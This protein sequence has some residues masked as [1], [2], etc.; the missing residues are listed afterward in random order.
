MNVD[1]ASIDLAGKPKCTLLQPASATVISS[2][3][4]LCVEDG[5]VSQ[6]PDEESS[7]ILP[8]VNRR[9]E[10]KRDRITYLMTKLGG[11]GVCGRR[12]L[13]KYAPAP[14][15]HEAADHQTYYPATTPL[16]SESLPRQS[17]R[18]TK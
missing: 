5:S 17:G 14:E 3:E 8:V 13:C 1:G 9:R 15:H 4:Q 7:H 2:V 12:S 16:Q 18:V 6:V 10:H 11:F